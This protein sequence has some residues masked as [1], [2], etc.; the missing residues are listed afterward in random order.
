V[1]Y[2]RERNVP[3]PSAAPFTPKS[4]IRG[5][6][7]C[8]AMTT[9][10][11]TG[12]DQW[13]DR[14]RRLETYRNRADPGIAL[15]STFYLVLLLIPRVAIT[16]F[17]SSVA[18]TALDVV[19]WIIITADLVYRLWLTT[20]RR[21]RRILIVALLLLLTGPLVFLAITERTRFLIRVALISVVALRAS[22]SVRF[23]F[24]LRSIVYII[25]AVVITIITFGVMM[26]VTERDAPNASITSLSTGIWWAI[27]TTSTVGYGD[28]Y[29]V[30]D[31][32]RVIASGLIF[33]GVAM[34]SILTATLASAFAN[35]SQSKAAFQL[36][37]LHDRVDRLERGTGYRRRERAPRRPRRRTPP[38]T[39]GGEPTEEDN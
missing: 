6:Q 32:G 38:P 23:F 30:T 9:A 8:I 28:T 19:F 20:D 5:D 22:N 15:L 1:R 16:S 36:S 37:Q 31:A 24:R 13:D 26:T 10:Q 18:I 7:S 14:T 12:N 27:E 4:T 21:E 34:F 35:R 17:E 25:S 11:T 3:A 2:D 29:P 39:V 33:F